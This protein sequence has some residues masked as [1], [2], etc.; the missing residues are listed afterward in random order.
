[1]IAVL[2]LPLIL[3]SATPPNAAWNCKDPQFQQE[4]NWCAGQDYEAA[5]QV[6]NT[7]WRAT[8]EAMKARDTEFAAGSNTSDSQPGWFASLLESQRSWLRYRDAQCRVDGYQARGGSLESFLVSSCKA[9]LTRARSEELK[10]LIQN[11]G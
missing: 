9:R 3:Q 10:A 4:M 8:R 2:V 6:M 11:P 5:D 1:M 7:Q